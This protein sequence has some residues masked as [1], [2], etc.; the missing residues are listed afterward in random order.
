MKTYLRKIIT[1]ILVLSLLLGSILS[2]SSCSYT[3]SFIGDIF[4]NLGKDGETRDSLTA[5]RGALLSSVSITADFT[6]EINDPFSYT[7]TTG[8]R[9]MAGSGV[10]YKLDKSTGDAYIITNYHVI[11]HDDAVTDKISE[12]IKVYLYGYESENY[13]ISAKYVGGAFD[14]D[15]AVLKVTGSDLLKISPARAAETSDSELVRVLD[16]VIAIGNAEREGISATKG[17]VSVISEDLKMKGPDKRTDITVRV[18]RVDT[19]INEGNSGGGLFDSQGRLIG[20]VNA[21]KIGEK[22]D[23]I[24]YAIPS[25]LAL[26]LADNIIYH[27]DEEFRGAY[28]Y[29]PGINVSEAEMSLE[30]D[31]D[32]EIVR[33]TRVVVTSVDQD[34]SLRGKILE[35]DTL[36]EIRVDGK[37]QRIT[38][39]YHVLEI[40]LTARPGSTVTLVVERNG[41]THTVSL[42]VTSDM[43]TAIK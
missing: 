12:S 42:T 24:A 29:T 41:V 10:I 2:L 33:V 39:L 38:A 19:A 21:K 7:A 35:Q 18:M 40:M 25:N 43:G 23:N 28:K 6:V 3:A 16:P 31:K 20:I 8:T 14:Y 11:Y 30:L 27:S 34:S 15:L 26:A 22:V 9:T 1:L 36:L 37:V 32:G 13:A 17:S 4:D 5:Q